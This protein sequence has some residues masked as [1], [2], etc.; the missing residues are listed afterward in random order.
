M[1]TVK[2]S[3]VQTTDIEFSHLY[4]KNKTRIRIPTVI[5]KWSHLEYN[6]FLQIRF[7]G[8]WTDPG[9]MSIAPT[10]VRPS[11]HRPSLVQQVVI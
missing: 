1:I 9:T 2:I 8:L 7:H 11:F 3:K 10:Y 5:V 6:G 4:N